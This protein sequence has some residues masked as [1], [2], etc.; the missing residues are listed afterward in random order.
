MGVSTSPNTI[1][2]TGLWQDLEC[3]ASSINKAWIMASH[4][5]E[6]LWENKKEGSQAFY[7]VRRKKKFQH[8]VSTCNLFDLRFVE[9]KSF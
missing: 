6:L 2:Y 4:F 5:S 9:L 1:F 7:L 3:I 8:Y